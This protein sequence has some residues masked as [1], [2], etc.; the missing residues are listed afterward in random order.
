MDSTILCDFRP[1]VKGCDAIA[2]PS[3]ALEWGPALR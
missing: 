3:S 2:H 1:R